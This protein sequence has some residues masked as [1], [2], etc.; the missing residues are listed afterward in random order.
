MFSEK[1]YRKIA[2]FL[3][4]GVVLLLGYLVVSLFTNREP[5]VEDGSVSQPVSKNE[6]I[7][8][9]LQ[10]YDDDFPEAEGWPVPT[11]C[12]LPYGFAE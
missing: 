2:I 11:G 12:L 6:E 1:E 8:I 9:D 4:I 7:F 5:E 10:D 3:G